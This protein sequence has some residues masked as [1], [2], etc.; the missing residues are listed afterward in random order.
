M[1]SSYKHQLIFWIGKYLSQCFFVCLLPKLYSYSSFT[2]QNSESSISMEIFSK[3]LTLPSMS[4]AVINLESSIIF[5]DP[6]EMSTQCLCRKME[7]HF[8]WELSVH[9]FSWKYIIVSSSAIALLCDTGQFFP[10]ALLR[11]ALSSDTMIRITKS[12]SVSVQNRTSKHSLSQST[13]ISRYSLLVS[14]LKRVKSKKLYLLST[15]PSWYWFIIPYYMTCICFQ[16]LLKRLLPKCFFNEHTF[17]WVST[18]YVYDNDLLN[19]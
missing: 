14:I 12:F 13:S 10:P 15:I 4:F 18:H 17:F 11:S 19:I 9:D 1:K 8:E 7:Y 5:L 16:Q 2:S 3:Q 6:Q